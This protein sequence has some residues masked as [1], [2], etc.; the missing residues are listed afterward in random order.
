MAAAKGS[1]RTDAIRAQREAAFDA[2]E[3]ASARARGEKHIGLVEARAMVDKPPKVTKAQMRDALEGPVCP[4]CKVNRTRNP[5][6]QCTP[7]LGPRACPSCAG[8]GINPMPPHDACTR[9][10]GTG[11]V[12]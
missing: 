4:T 1:S 11:L 10:P 7:C 2:R 9:C 3:K 12:P 5:S 8:S 6:K